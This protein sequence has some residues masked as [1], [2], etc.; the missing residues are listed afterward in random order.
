MVLKLQTYKEALEFYD[1]FMAMWEGNNQWV[2]E[3]LEEF[4]EFKVPWNDYSRFRRQCPNCL[5]YYKKNIITCKVCGKNL[6]KQRLQT[7]G[8][9]FPDRTKGL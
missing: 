2:L 3:H 1:R 4:E 5:I 9:C 7:F 8:V 6:Q